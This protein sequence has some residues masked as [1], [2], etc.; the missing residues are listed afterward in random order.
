M[1]FNGEPAQA[2]LPPEAELGAVSLDYHKVA[3]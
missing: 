3:R 1:N 2:Q